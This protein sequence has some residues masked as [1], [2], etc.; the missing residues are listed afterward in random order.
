MVVPRDALLISYLL[1]IIDRGRGRYSMGFD[2][3]KFTMPIQE[4]LEEIVGVYQRHHVPMKKVSQPRT[5]RFIR[6]IN[7]AWFLQARAIS[8]MAAVIACF[9]W[10]RY[11][12]ERTMTIKATRHKLAEFGIG[13]TTSRRILRQMEAVHLV[14]VTWQ[15]TRAPDVT[16]LVD[17]A[18]SG[19]ARG[20]SS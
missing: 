13:K 16:I 11:G 1:L 3:K 12:L 8:P 20:I 7:L 14:A 17:D 19:T 6:P 9:L 5:G 18:V 10:Y 2:Y 4:P 15:K